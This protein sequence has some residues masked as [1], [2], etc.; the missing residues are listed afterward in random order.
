MKILIKP[1]SLALVISAIWLAIRLSVGFN[2]NVKLDEGVMVSG[3][4][5]SL[6]IFYALL[7]A[8]AFATAWQQWVAVEEAVKTKDQQAFLKHKD[9]RMP[10]TVKALILLFSV[11]L[12]GAFFL[13]SFK[14]ILN[15]LYSIFS[16]T[17]ALSIYWVVIMDLDDPFDGDWNIQVPKEWQHLIKN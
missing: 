8:F 7:A 17:L 14:N 6:A 12:I 1:I 10:R 15:G 2:Q 16:I 4:I 3:T 9:K 11:L 5:A 13:I